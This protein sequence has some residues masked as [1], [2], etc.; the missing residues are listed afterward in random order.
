[1]LCVYVYEIIT[2][3]PI[4]DEIE[5]DSLISDLTYFMSD[6]QGIVRAL[7]PWKLFW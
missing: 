4:I 5:W 1:M 7:R 3:S 6:I 2:I